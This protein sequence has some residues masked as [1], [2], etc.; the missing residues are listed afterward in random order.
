MTF[1]NLIH[2][3]HTAGLPLGQ[4]YLVLPVE[5]SSKDTPFPATP[6]E[7][8]EGAFDP[9]ETAKRDRLIHALEKVPP[10][11]T[12]TIVLRLLAATKEGEWVSFQTMVATFEAE[13]V[14]HGKD[15][16][17]RG[18]AALRDLSW[19]VKHYMPETDLVGTNVAID[20]LATRRRFGKETRYQLT[21]LGRAA[22]EH[23]ANKK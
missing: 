11:D 21:K 15:A 7:V 2:T 18:A 10:N 19:Q 5:F 12:R 8:G 9:A 14:A 13:N 6:D 22:L 16:V 17:E 1:E 4:A 23:I 20:V 3:L